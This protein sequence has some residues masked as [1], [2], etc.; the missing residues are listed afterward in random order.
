MK[1]LGGRSHWAKCFTLTQKEVAALYP[2]TYP[3]FLRVR[4]KYDKHGV[5]TNT[6]LSELFP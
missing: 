6:L 1:S 3:R 5:F 4:D 2:N